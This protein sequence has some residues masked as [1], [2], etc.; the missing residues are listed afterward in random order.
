MK[1]RNVDTGKQPR[2]PVKRTP[3]FA[4]SVYG[5]YYQLLFLVLMACILNN[6]FFLFVQ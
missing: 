6:E 3:K 5:R 4:D 2:R 1:R